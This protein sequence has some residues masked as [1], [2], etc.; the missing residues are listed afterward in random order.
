MD[1]YREYLLK[2][3]YL[4][5]EFDFYKLYP[6]MSMLLKE[7]YID[8]YDFISWPEQDDKLRHY[9]FRSEEHL[10]K[11]IFKDRAGIMKNN[12]N[13]HYEVM[14]RNIERIK[15]VNVSDFH[16]DNG[17]A[18]LNA[19]ETFDWNTVYGLY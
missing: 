17:I 3:I 7:D 2:R 14:A 5:R 1:K 16:V 4:P 15:K 11:R 9:P 19:E 18:D 12:T 8:K 13:W 10:K 6:A